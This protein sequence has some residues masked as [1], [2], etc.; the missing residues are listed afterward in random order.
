V[1]Y[2]YSSL[3]KLCAGGDEGFEKVAR[4]EQIALRPE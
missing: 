4:E 3:T 1:K 2:F